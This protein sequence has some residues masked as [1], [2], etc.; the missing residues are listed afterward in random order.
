[1]ITV[2]ALKKVQFYATLALLLGVAQ[3]EATELYA[4]EGVQRQ[5]T[6]K[7]EETISRQLDE[8]WEKKE[9]ERSHPRFP[10]RIAEKKPANP[11]LSASLVGVQIAP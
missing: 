6:E 9:R 2:E 11:G 1:M 7:I 4:V 5:L 3:V 10:V 8:C